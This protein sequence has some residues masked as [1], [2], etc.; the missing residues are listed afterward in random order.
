MSKIIIIFDENIYNIPMKIKDYISRSIQSYP[1]LYKCDSYYES[2]LR[3]LNHIFFTNGNGLE[4]AETENSEDGGYVVEPKY[5]MDIKTDNWNRIKDKPYGKEKYKELSKDYFDSIIYQVCGLESPIEV[6]NNGGDNVYYRYD[7]KIKDREDFYHPR[8]VEIIKDNSFSPYPF[9]KNFCII[10]DVYYNNL[11][12]QPDWIEESI[13]LCKETLKYFF[14]EELYK[15]D[16]CYPTENS[17]KRDFNHFQEREKEGGSNSIKELRKIWGYKDSDVC[18]DIEE[19]KNHK[20]DSWI[21]F[22]KRQIDFLNDYLTRF[23]NGFSAEEFHNNYIKKNKKKESYTKY[24]IAS[25]L[26]FKKV[27]GDDMYEKFENTPLKE[28]DW[29]DIEIKSNEILSNIPNINDRFKIDFFND[30]NYSMLDLY[31]TSILNYGYQNK[32]KNEDYTNYQ[33]ASKELL[34]MLFGDDIYN[35]IQDS[36]MNEVIWNGVDITT[37]EIIKCVPNIKD[38]FEQS[39]LNY[40]KDRNYSMLDIYIMSVF[41]YGY[42]DKCE[43]M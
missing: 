33:D 31:I 3:V 37:S 34:K 11:F 35:Q 39:S 12:M 8:L 30:R 42:Q 15:K 24:Q 23:D 43:R 41:H 29:K 40:F 25:K 1:T 28:I 10:C 21:L 7:K 5:K 22:R 4:V 32:I 38:R 9:S 18:P 20:W 36:S 2:K 17:I 14:N 16:V 13:I 26:L 27:F 19:I 6:I